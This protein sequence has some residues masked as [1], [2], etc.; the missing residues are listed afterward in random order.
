MIDFCCKHTEKYT[1]L[2]HKKKQSYTKIYDQDGTSETWL[3][4][5]LLNTESYE[6]LVYDELPEEFKQFIDDIAPTIPELKSC[7]E[8]CF[9]NFAH[10]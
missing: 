2:T 8:W 3:R 5:L 4:S 1:V 6:L 10:S 9:K 7:D